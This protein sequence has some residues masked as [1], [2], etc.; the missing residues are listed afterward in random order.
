MTDEKQIDL[1]WW[2]NEI[3][4]DDSSDFIAVTAGVGSGKTYG[5]VQA[6]Y[7]K[8]TQSPQALRWFYAMPIYELI[9]N[10]FFPTWIKFADSIGMIENVHYKLIKSPFPQIRLCNKQVVDCLSMQRPDKIKATEYAGGVVDEPGVCPDESIERLIERSRSKLVKK[11]QILFPGTPEGLDNYFAKRFNSDDDPRWDHSVKKDHTLEQIV[12]TDKGDKKVRYRRF[13][14]STYDNLHNL[15]D[16][17]VPNL[18]DTYG[19]NEQFV[20]SYIYGYFVPLFTGGCYSE[21]KSRIHDIADIDP[22]KYLPIYLT[23]DFN[24]NPVSWISVQD[25]NFEEFGTRVKRKVAIHESEFGNDLLEKACVEFAF[26]HP[27]EAFKVTPIY[28]YG[29]RSGLSAS[30]KSSLNDYERIK[31]AL[32]ELGYENVYIRSLS[33]NPLQTTAVDALNYWFRKYELVLCQRLK[34]LRNSLQQT[35]WK[36]GTKQIDK[37][38]GETHTHFSDAL[39]YLAYALQESKYKTYTSFNL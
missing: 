2:V 34:N 1:A 5:V 11:V 29:D 21:Y 32:E 4:Q 33:Y 38:N 13:R 30:H 18:L 23:F 20:R 28:L 7:Y 27:V 6:L 22:D 35:R 16:N 10:T 3:M 36:P 17:Y 8:M 25:I 14:I 15:S 12:S 26:K 39:K 19:S 24:A 31:A 9:R 37:P